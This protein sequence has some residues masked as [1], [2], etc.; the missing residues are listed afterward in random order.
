MGTSK[1]FF[2]DAKSRFLKIKFVFCFLW[3][4][5]LKI[6]NEKLKGAV[7]AFFG[8]EGGERGA[9]GGREGDERGARGGNSLP[10]TTSHKETPKK[11]TKS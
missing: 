7:K 1:E 6:K 9:R 5:N 2:S 11:I 4:R 3:E 8:V 10:G